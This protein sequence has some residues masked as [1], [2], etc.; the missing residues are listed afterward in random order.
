MDPPSYIYSC[1]CLQLVKRR[2]VTF[3]DP[4][5]DR[6]QKALA[7]APG[8]ENHR[9]GPKISSAVANLE[10]FSLWNS[11][12]EFF[13]WDSHPSPDLP[14]FLAGR[15]REPRVPTVAVPNTGVL[16]KSHLR[17]HRKATPPQLPKRRQVT[18]L[19]P[20]P[21][22][23][24]TALARAPGLENHRRGPTLSSAAAN[25]EK[26]SLRNSPR[27]IFSGIHTP[28]Q[29]CRDSQPAV[30]ESLGRPFDRTTFHRP[31]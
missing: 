13:F 15:G 16:G 19:D 18:F 17:V 2:Q 8:L 23:G 10:K 5:P 24:Q 27:G 3:F 25:L 20:K 9:R 1:D 31:S 21:G 6:G 7:R 4:K 12:G 22:R 30:V 28:V 26:F 11:P 29:S 14:R